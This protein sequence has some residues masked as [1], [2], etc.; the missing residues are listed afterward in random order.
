MTV[1]ESGRHLFKFLR[2]FLWSYLIRLSLTKRMLSDASAIFFLMPIYWYVM[3]AVMKTFLDCFSDLLL[4]EKEL[5]RLHGGVSMAVP[6]NTESDEPPI[7]FDEL[8]Q[9]SAEY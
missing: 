7:Y 8:F 3:S 2:Y 1:V 6:S 5:R 4:I 9:L